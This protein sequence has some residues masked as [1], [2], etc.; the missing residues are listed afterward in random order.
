[1]R[2]KSP[3]RNWPAFA[4]A[5]QKVIVPIEDGSTNPRYTVDSPLTIAASP[6]VPPRVPPGLG[7]HTDETS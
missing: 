7:E 2:A 6:K 4:K 1:V 3:P 5:I